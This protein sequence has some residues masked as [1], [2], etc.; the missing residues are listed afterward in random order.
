MAT[1]KLIRGLDRRTAVMHNNNLISLGDTQL[2]IMG[3]V[4]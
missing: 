3:S 4:L 2:A 1:Q